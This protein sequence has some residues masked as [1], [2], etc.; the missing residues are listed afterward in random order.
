M[1]RSLSNHA[2]LTSTQSTQHLTIENHCFPSALRSTAV[3]DR[4][5]R[6][7]GLFGPSMFNLDG[8]PTPARDPTPEAVKCS[9]ASQVIV[10]I[11]T[12]KA[13]GMR[14][15]ITGNTFTRSDA[16]GSKGLYKSTG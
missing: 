11:V 6:W 9:S 5:V 7:C 13:T 4:T 2:A 14:F 1:Y 3:A 16:E 12:T 8:P 10:F 15:W